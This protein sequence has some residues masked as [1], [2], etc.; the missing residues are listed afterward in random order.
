M[1]SEQ[2]KETLQQLLKVLDKIKHKKVIVEGLRDKVVLRSLGFTDVLTIERGLWETVEDLGCVPV[3]LTDFDDEGRRI[4][5]KLDLFLRS[6]A[7]HQTRK[8]VGLMFAEI[9]IKTV[10]ELKNM[11]KGV[12]VNVETGAISVKIHNIRALR[13]GRNR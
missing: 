8:K 12:D 4:A 10:E 1:Y 2:K 5:A 13:G 7:D 3:I 9:K 6:R 11:I